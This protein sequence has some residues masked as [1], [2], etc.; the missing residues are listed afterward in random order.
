MAT[1]ISASFERFRSNLEITSL[2]QATVSGR[3][4]NVRDAVARRLT[5]NDSFVTGSYGRHTM[6]GPL[7][8]A[9]I[10]LFVVLDPGY[11]KT[12][13]YAT[14]LNR[15]RGVLLETYTK[16]PRISRN[17]QAVTITFTDFVVDVVPAFH[18][19]GGGYLIPNTVERTWIPTNPKMHETFLSNANAAHKGELVPLVKMLKA[20]NRT[21]GSP[22]R[23]FYLELLV[24]KVLRGV[25]I[26]DLPS[27]C[28]FIFDKGREAVKYTVFDPA[29]LDS[30]QV[31][32]IASGTVAQA[33]N[34]FVTALTRAQQAER[35][36]TAGNVAAA[37]N[38]WRRI[39]GDFFPA[40]G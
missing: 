1:T 14:L 32:G 6:I 25:K 5:V 2:Q 33:V 34:R 12:D 13:G 15:V 3:Q 36:A 40:Y 29:G 11:F 9:D 35:L 23:S 28:R 16:S 27:G 17:G 19:L 18:R 24:E 30:H 39:F 8:T 20:W 38:E 10:D 31:R 4:R 37:V 21:N 26:S 22:L 7:S